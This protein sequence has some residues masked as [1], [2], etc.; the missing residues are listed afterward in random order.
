MDFG[1][2]YLFN[3]NPEDMRHVGSLGGRARA[4]NLRLRKARPVPVIGELS[5]PRQE[6][7]AE[8]IRHRCPMPLAGRC[9]AWRG[10]CEYLCHAMTAAIVSVIS[11]ATRAPWP[12]RNRACRVARRRRVPFGRT[13]PCL[14]TLH[15]GQP[16]A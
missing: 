9:G 13:P 12:R 8:A 14:D 10:R 16:G 4:R 11:G 15:T 1:S 7:A 5:R 3:K 6:T 2:A